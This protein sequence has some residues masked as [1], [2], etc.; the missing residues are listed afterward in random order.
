MAWPIRST[1]TDRSRPSSRTEPSGSG[2]LPSYAPISKAIPEA[3]DDGPTAAPPLCAVRRPMS[4]SP[5]A[6]ST[7]LRSCKLR[8]SRLLGP[9]GRVSPSARRICVRHEATN[10]LGSGP[11]RDEFNGS[12]GFDL[13]PP[14]ESNSCQ[15]YTT[16]EYKHFLPF[17]KDK[18]RNTAK[19]AFRFCLTHWAHGRIEP[20]G[21][22]YERTPFRAAGPGLNKL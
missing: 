18:N 10:V 17:S 11:R 7:Q 9:F 15:G 5:G 19:R 8:G 6:S 14:E 1:R 3:N 20:A 4:F 21:S 16:C 2:R 12:R 13:Y 22:E